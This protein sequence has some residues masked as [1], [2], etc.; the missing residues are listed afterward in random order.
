MPSQD[1]K[2]MMPIV[3]ASDGH[4]DGDLVDKNDRDVDV[5]AKILAAARNERPVT[6]EEMEAVRRKIDWHMIPMLFVCLQLS[7]WDKV[8]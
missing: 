4:Q 7:G 3:G 8:V 2:D 6:E 5:A 1:R